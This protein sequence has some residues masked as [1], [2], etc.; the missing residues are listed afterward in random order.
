MAE[1]FDGPMEVVEGFLDAFAAMDF[2]TALSLLADDVE[3]TNIPLGTVHG[4]AGVREVLEPFFAPI[5]ENEFLLS[6]R[7]VSGPVVF[8]ERLDRHRLEHGWRAL[9]VNSVFEVHDSKITVWRDYFDLATAA[10]IHEAD[11]A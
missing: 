11:A 6:R 7:A 4:H 8:V 9:P 2:G 10:K 1:K 5:L 3:Y